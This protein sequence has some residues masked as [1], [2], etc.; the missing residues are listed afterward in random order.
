MADDVVANPG[1]GGATFATDDDGTRHWPYAKAAWGA[2]NTQTPVSSGAAALPIQDGGNSITVDG[3][4]SVSGT[5]TVTAAAAFPVTDNAGSLT[6]DNGGTFAVQ[7]ACAG[8][9]AHDGVDS[10]NPQKIGAVAI[11][12]GT[13][14][15]AVSAADRTNLYANR[16]GV[17]F[18]IGGHPNI[19]TIEAAYTTAQ[20]DAAIVTVGSGAKIVVTQIQ[21]VT[22]SANTASVGLR[23]GFGTANTP[24]TTGVVATH[25]GMVPGAGISRGD[26]SGILGVGADNEDLRVTSSVP[27]GGSL[28]VLVSYYTIES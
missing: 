6:V 5:A 16:A 12:H 19:I 18:F 13:N 15:T 8:D 11:A 27:T 17:P 26:G 22:D 2:N 7:A 10:G 25:P 23:V 1:V 4:V 24:T 21:A 28:R 3:A 9:V 20:T 14:P